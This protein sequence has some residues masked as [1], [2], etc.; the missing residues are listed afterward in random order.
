MNC[1]TRLRVDVN[2]MGLVDKDTL[3]K[4][5]NSGIVEGGPNNIQ[6]VVG[7]K[8]QEVADAVNHALGREGD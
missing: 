2:D 4:V 7:M 1:F 8:V 5:Q 3:N 6:V